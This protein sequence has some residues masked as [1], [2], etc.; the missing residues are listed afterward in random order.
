MQLYWLSLYM[1]MVVGTPKPDLAEYVQRE[2]PTFSWQQIDHI[3]HDSGQIYNLHLVSQIWK[4]IQWKHN[5]Q[6]FVPKSIRYPDTM[7]LLVSGGSTDSQPPDKDNEMGLKLAQMTGSAFAILHQVPNQPLYDGRKEDDLIAHTFEKYLETKDS[8]WLLLFPMVKSATQAMT[9]LTQFTAQK[10]RGKIEKFVITGA[11]KRG[12]TSWLTA[13]IDPRI[14]AT[15]PLVIDVLNMPAQM[16]YQ[17]ATWGQ[18]SEQI[19]DYTVR[20]LQEKLEEEEGKSLTA[21]VD[22]YSYRS[23]LTMPKLSVIGTNDQY[24]VLDALNLYWSDLVQPNFVLYVPNSG[25]D[26]DDREL[27]FAGITGFYR[28]I[29]SGQP[30]PKLEWSH[31]QDGD[32]LHLQ[33]SAD[34]KPA[35]TRLWVTASS[36]RDFRSASW[37]AVPVQEKE[38]GKFSGQVEIHQQQYV[39]LFGECVFIVDGQ[40]C[41]LSTQINIG[42]ITQKE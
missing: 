2:E 12:W 34:Q 20:G 22:P 13:A 36:K 18:Y 9:A 41:P 11:S 28:Y 4:K 10:L 30:L 21:L 17:K 6:V 14:K 16:E 1:T 26:L 15:I 24:W 27:V 35:Q 38:D 32:R 37:V 33:F 31:R 42:S 5:L 7:L 19:N 23:Q 3:Q 40:P 25:H 39:A 29:A 8:S